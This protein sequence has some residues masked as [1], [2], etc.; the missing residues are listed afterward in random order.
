MCP[1]A[2]YFNSHEPFSTAVIGDVLSGI[3]AEDLPDLIPGVVRR[4]MGV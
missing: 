2:W 1:H 4:L 3:V